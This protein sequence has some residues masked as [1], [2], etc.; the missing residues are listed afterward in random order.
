[1]SLINKLL[2]HDFY[3]GDRTNEKQVSVSEV[4]NGNVLQAV[5]ARLHEVP[6]P[7]SLGQSHI[8]SLADIGLRQ[9]AIEGVLGEEVVSGCRVLMNL[10]NGVILSGEPDIL[11]NEEKVIYDLKITKIYSYKEIIKQGSSHQ[12]AKQINYYRLMFGS[13]YSMVLLLA[14]KDQSEVENSKSYM[15]SAFV[16]V[17]IARIDDDKLIEEA[18][19]FSDEV[20]FHLENGTKPEK[21]ED[22]W[23][24]DFK[25]RH[26]C[27]Y[28]V[29]CDYAKKK[30]LIKENSGDWLKVGS[31]EPKREELNDIGW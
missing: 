9:L 10:P 15:E 27:S 7:K 8:G 6:K 29:F 24:N 2:S 12:Y 19:R 13:D 14:L 16:E 28:N 22:T 30:K 17:P 3:S 4:A 23:Q 25:C 11:D 20:K 21:C 18:V 26:Y 31:S 5:L 1:M